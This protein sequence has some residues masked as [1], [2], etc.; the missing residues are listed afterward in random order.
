MKLINKYLVYFVLVGLII[1]TSCKSTKK[2]VV[3]VST[4]LEHALLWKIEGKE[5]AS[6]SYVFGT[7][8]II[9]KE[10]YFLPEGLLTAF[11]SATKIMFEIDVNDMTDMSKMMGLMNKIMMSDGQTLKE[12]VSPEDFLILENH[13]KKIGIPLMFMQRMKPMFLE[14]YAMSDMSPED[15][16]SGKMKSYEIELNNLAKETNKTTSGLE[17]IDYQLSIFDS[18]PYEYQAKR[19]VEAVKLGSE[20]EQSLDELVKLYKSMDIDAMVE[21]MDEEED[22][23]GFEELLL[24]GR[25]KNWIPIMEQ[26]MQAE[27][28]FFAVGAA[29]LGGNHGVIRLL[30]AKGYKLTPINPQL[31]K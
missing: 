12:F 3:P 18:I 2:T 30:K 9:S 31:N 24:N 22:F 6:P 23:K 29:H 27:S 21:M 4:S 1:S 10:D 25:N 11:E 20:N 17:T 8:H 13:F 14:V 19:L 16:Q 28:S 5:L 26:S 7:I 15:I